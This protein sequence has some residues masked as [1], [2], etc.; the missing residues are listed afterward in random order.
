MITEYFRS[1]LTVIFR[2]H[3]KGYARGSGGGPLDWQSVIMKRGMPGGPGVV[4]RTAPLERTGFL[5]RSGR[6][7]RLGVEITAN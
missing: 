1:Y 4:P 6:R 7:Y 3:E 2:D 5:P